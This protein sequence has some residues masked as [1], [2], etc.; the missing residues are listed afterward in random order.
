MINFKKIIRKPYYYVPP[1]PACKSYLTGRFVLLHRNIETEWMIDEALR[2]GEIINPQPEIPRHNA[3]CLN[4]DYTWL[5]DI[6]L[7]L[8]TIAR[9][10]EEKE[11]RSTNIILKDRYLKN[12]EAEKE[13]NQKRSA[14]IKPFIKFIGKL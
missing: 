3:F 2:N 14:I 1:C 6:R 11:N 10:S 8:F 9:I 13:R 5:E 7:K 12:N 4:C